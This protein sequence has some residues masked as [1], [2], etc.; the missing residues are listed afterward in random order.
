MRLNRKESL[1]AKACDG[2]HAQV[3]KG[4]S[5]R[6]SSAASDLAFV[7]HGTMKRLEMS[8]GKSSGP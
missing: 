6:A 1:D 3:G 4:Q 8:K 5:T 7:C 2:G